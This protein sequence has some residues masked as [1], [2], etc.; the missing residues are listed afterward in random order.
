[1]CVRGHVVINDCTL[2]LN[3]WPRVFLW[4]TCVLFRAMAGHAMV[5]CM[6]GNMAVMMFK[7][8]IRMDLNRKSFFKSRR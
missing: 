5:A 7:R 1:M 2:N 6:H 4:E 3:A 8:P